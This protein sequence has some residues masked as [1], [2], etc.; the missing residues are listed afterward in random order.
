MPLNYTDLLLS[1]E[2]KV[3][4][5]IIIERDNKKCRN[6]QN[7]RIIENTK[8]ALLEAPFYNSHPHTRIG[9]KIPDRIGIGFLMTHEIIELL[10]P[11]MIIHYYK[12]ETDRFP[13]IQSI[14]LLNSSELKNYVNC[15]QERLKVYQ[16]L[17]KGTTLDL[18]EEKA[19]IIN[20]L[21]QPYKEVKLT[22]SDFRLITWVYIK[23]LN[24]H[25]TYYQEGLKPWQYPDDSLIT[26][27]QICHKELHDTQKIPCR[28]SLGNNIGELTP[29][30]RCGGTG[31]FPEF[32]H[33]EEGICFRCNGAKYDEFISV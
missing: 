10:S 21:T 19:K 14:R 9:H 27:C 3:K 26:Y 15:T 29:C 1:Q 7:R 25:H 28:D 8:C 30:S 20:L 12:S 13:W 11:P 6:C 5:N 2:W 32:Y 22:D 23:G 31:E 18:E 4:R 16:L 33:V 24:V 17:P